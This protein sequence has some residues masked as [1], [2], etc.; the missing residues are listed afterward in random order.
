MIIIIFLNRI[1]TTVSNIVSVNNKLKVIKLLCP[2][3]FLASSFYDVCS[4]VANL[5]EMKA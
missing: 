2:S 3:V 4:S 1:S 5:D